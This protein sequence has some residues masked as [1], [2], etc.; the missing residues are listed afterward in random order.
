MGS[1]Q[2]SYG[3]GPSHP[4]PSYRPTTPTPLVKPTTLD[5]SYAPRLTLSNTSAPLTS[6]QT[7]YHTNLSYRRFPSYRP[8]LSSN[9]ALFYRPV[10]SNTYIEA[11]IPTCAG[12]T[13]STWCLEDERY[14]ENAIKRAIQNHLDNFNSLYTDL[15]EFETELSIERLNTI[16]KT[17]LCPSKTSYIHPLR[18]QNTEGKWLI[19]VNNIGVSYK[20]YIQTVRIEECLTDNNPCPLV[21]MCYDSKCLQKFIY[22]RFLVFDPYD[23]SFPFAIETFK[24]PASC[25][26]LLDSFNIH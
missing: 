11:S 12:L 9:P 22:Q 5:L 25:A 15:V 2:Y 6:T 10:L 17:Y 18:A 7:I 23:L 8:A 26:C 4:P 21:P 24:L 19:I 1:I 20:T 3:L 16:N 13:N 14:P